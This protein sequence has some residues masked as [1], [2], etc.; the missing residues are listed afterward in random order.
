MP[1]PNSGRHEETHEDALPTWASATPHFIFGQPP[2]K[3][4]L[5]PLERPSRLA[6]SQPGSARPG[7]V[8]AGEDLEGAVDG[9]VQVKTHWRRR[10]LAILLLLGAV[11]GGLTPTSIQLYR[12]SRRAPSVDS[13]AV[14]VEAALQW[15]VGLSVSAAMRSNPEL[16]GRR[17]VE[18]G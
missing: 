17:K 11:G 14:Y 6:S 15:T 12:K 3:T 5:P 10:L 9:R 1:R 18:G 2:P 16:L 7:S 8:G 13:R 4:H